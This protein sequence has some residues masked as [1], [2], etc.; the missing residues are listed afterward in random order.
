MAAIAR[1]S[2]PVLALL[3]ASKAQASCGDY[4]FRGH[5][6]SSDAA[7]QKTPSDLTS[8]GHELPPMPT[9]DPVPCS[10]PNCSRGSSLPLAP[11]T[12][13]P[14]GPD[15]W[16]LL[17]AS[18]LLLAFDPGVVPVAEFPQFPVRRSFSVYHPPR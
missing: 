9:E 7:R 4:V 10:G 8:P 2:I 18:V 5:G 6:G 14:P 11:V 17:D 12:T 13:P 16:P 1:V 15:L 3:L